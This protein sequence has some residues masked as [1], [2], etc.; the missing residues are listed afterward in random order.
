MRWLL[1]QGLPRS[2]AAIL[3]E[4]QED[5]VHVGDIGMA[6]APDSVIIHHALDSNRII[7]TLDADFHTLLALSGS[8]KPSVIRIREEGLKGP[9]L[10]ALIL[11]IAGQFGAELRR[12]SVMTFH[13][14]KIRHRALPL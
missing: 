8:A 3:N 12:G 2:A 9:Q 13:S 1:D 10:A 14:G 11:R 6:E 4:A 5:A 7:V